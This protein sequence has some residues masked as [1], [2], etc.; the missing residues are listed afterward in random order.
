MKVVADKEGFDQ[1]QLKALAKK[2]IEALGPIKDW[3]KTEIQQIGT[4]VSGAT[5]DELKQ[6]KDEAI[7]AIT[8]IVT[9]A[10]DK[11]KLDALGDKLK[12]LTQQAKDSVWGQKFVTLSAKAKQALLDC[13]STCKQKFVDVVIKVKEH[14]A[15]FPAKLKEFI[16][17]ASQVTPEDVKKLF[18]EKKNEIT[19]IVFRVTTNNIQEVSTRITEYSK[20][21]DNMVDTTALLNVDAVA[22]EPNAAPPTPEASS[23]GKVLPSVFS[24]VLAGVCL[25]V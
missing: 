1:N 16:D 20:S 3:T 23:V 8:P 2:A 15:D 7:A 13:A 19:T 11:S 4:I 5:P 24:L 22:V 10:M 25:I 14:S 6:L 9:K 18:E 17:K 12:Q 21:A